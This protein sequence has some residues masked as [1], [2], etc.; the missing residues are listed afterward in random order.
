MK[1]SN[2]KEIQDPTEVVTPS[3]KKTR[4]GGKEREKEGIKIN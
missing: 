2:F 1:V 3:C 4:W